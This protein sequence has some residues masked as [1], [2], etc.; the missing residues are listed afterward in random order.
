MKNTFY[1]SAIEDDHA[2][3]SPY[4]LR[5]CYNDT[6]SAK[7]LITVQIGQSEFIVNQSFRFRKVDKKI[8][9]DILIEIHHLR[10]VFANCSIEAYP[11]RASHGDVLNAIEKCLTDCERH[12]RIDE[13][14]K[15]KVED[16]IVERHFVDYHLKIGTGLFWTPSYMAQYQ[17]PQLSKGYS[18]RI[19]WY[20]N[21]L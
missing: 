4:G 19:Y 17:L 9:E 12:E 8:L 1:R 3:F 21:A 7:P 14:D 6:P 16:K 11:K 18:G 2:L 15:L 10:Q 20:A 5:I 13:V